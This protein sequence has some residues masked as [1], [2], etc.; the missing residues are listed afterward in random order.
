MTL[1]FIARNAEKIQM[2]PAS[3]VIFNDGW[4]FGEYGD[5]W[6]WIFVTRIFQVF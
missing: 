1:F 4:Q 3:N 2:F 6:R 5:L